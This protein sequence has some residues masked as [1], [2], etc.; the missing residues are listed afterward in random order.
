MGGGF[1]IL[2]VSGPVLEAPGQLGL[3]G[4]G[5]ENTGSRVTQT[6]QDFRSFF[7]RASR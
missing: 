6:L 2:K 4:G 7:A 5:L 1:Q 3:E